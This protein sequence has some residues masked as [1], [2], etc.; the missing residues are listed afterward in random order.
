M[1]VGDRTEPRPEHQAGQEL[2][3]DDPAE[4]TR[5]KLDD[6][7]RQRDDLGPGAGDRGQLPGE[8]APERGRAKGGH[9]RPPVQQAA[10]HR[11]TDH[12][13]VIAATARTR[14]KRYVPPAPI[15]RAFVGAARLGLVSMPYAWTSR[16]SVAPMI[17]GIAT[18]PGLRAPTS[19]NRTIRMGTYSAALP[20]ALI[21]MSSL[22]AG[23]LG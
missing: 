9:S 2:Q 18:T 19:R 23:I 13:D 16:A 5:I 11:V 12:R 7:P 8:V 4:R 6:H 14:P 17:N 15:S 3:R 20:C 21:A 10:H 22:L 1:P